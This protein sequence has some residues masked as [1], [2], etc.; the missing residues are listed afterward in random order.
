[1]NILT[2]F[3]APAAFLPVWRLLPEGIT[4]PV[5]ARHV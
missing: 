1:M 2:D 4:R 5:D 3:A